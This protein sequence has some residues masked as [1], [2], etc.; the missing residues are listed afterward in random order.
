MNNK[1]SISICI[2]VF[3]LVLGTAIYLLFRPTT[4]LMFHWVSSVG[5]L[6]SIETLRTF[7][8]KI[9]SEVPEWIVYSLPFAFWIS[10]YLLFVRAIWWDSTSLIRHVWFWIIP[11]IAITTELAQNVN[12]LPGHYD[13]IDLIAII[14]AIVFALVMPEIYLLNK[15]GNA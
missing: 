13:P 8:I 2:A 1:Q 3:C 9:D 15:G 10:S 5:W 6:G 4:L 11:V 14:F 12:M 7:V